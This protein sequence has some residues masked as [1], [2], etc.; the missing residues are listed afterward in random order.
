M[1]TISLETLSQRVSATQD[2]C[3]KE[4]AAIQETTGEDI[5]V[6]GL[7]REVMVY[8][9]IAEAI[10]EEFDRIMAYHVPCV[11]AV[12]E[13]KDTVP[14]IQTPMI[15]FLVNDGQVIYIGQSV[16][17]ANRVGCHMRNK[18]F[19]HVYYVSV[20]AK[21]MRMA[22]AVNIWLNNPKLN[23]DRFT[24]I[25]LFRYIARKMI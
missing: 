21:D 8:S 2:A 1:T 9:W 6:E 19:S 7:G 11:T 13:A 24:G 23:K 16:G 20:P 12:A 18:E 22:E 15:Y 10:I 25:D 5:L 4:L 14:F 3:G 17:L